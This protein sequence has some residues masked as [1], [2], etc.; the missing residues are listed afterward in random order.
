MAFKGSF[1]ITQ[2]DED[3]LSE[4]S[5][6]IKVSHASIKQTYSGDMSGESSVEFLMSYQSQMSAKFTGFETFVGVINGM[7]GTVTFQHSGT[8]ESGVASSEFVSVEEAA[9][10]E[11]MGK[12]LRG[13]FISGESGKAEYTI[14]VDNS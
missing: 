3:T 12:T 10:G 5:E 9:T 2:W 1:T 8:F 6:G 13:R 7:R 14:D 4:R 11:L